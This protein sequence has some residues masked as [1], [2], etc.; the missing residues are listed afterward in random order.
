MIKVGMLIAE[1]YEIIEKIGTGG[2]SDVYRAKCHKLNRFVAVKVLKQEFSENTDFVSKFRVEA[3]A[4]AGLMHP[5]IVNV[6]DV[7]EEN[8]F[9]YIVME[10][11]EGITLK[12]Y[13]EK[14]ARLSVK[15]AVSIAIQVSMGIEAS[16][17]NH[18]IHRDIKPQN[19]IISK[20]G[21]VKVTDFGIAKAATSNTITSSV[22]GS[23][24]YTSPEQV[25]GGF[26][27]E[28]SDIYSLGITL[29]EMLTGRVPFNGETTVAV[30]IKHIQEPM[31]SPRNFVPEIPISVEQIVMKCTQKSPD[32]RYQYAPELIE[33]LKK[34][35]I[36]PDENFVKLDTEDVQGVTKNITS[37]E[38]KEIKRQS[39][40]SV[41]V[42][43]SGTG[44][45][46]VPAEA[47]VAVPAVVPVKE[48]ES[49]KEAKSA[50]SNGQAKPKNGK[51]SKNASGTP[52]KGNGES[53]PKSGAKTQKPSGKNAA[54]SRP[55]KASKSGKPS[56]KPAGAASGKKKKN[57]SNYEEE[58][59]P[60]ME[61]LTTVLIVVATVIIGC[62]FIY[63]FTKALGIN[64]FSTEPVETEAEQ[65]AQVEMIA[66]DNMDAAVA[67]S[68]LTAMG[69]TVTK[70]YE[71]S[72]AVPE[73]QVIR[74][75]VAVGTMVD[76]GSN[77]VLTVSSGANGA[78]VPSVLGLSRAEATAALE[79]EG[80]VVT[81]NHVNSDTVARDNVVSQM[82]EGESHI[83]RG[84]T[85]EITVSLGA[86]E[87]EVQVPNILNQT[88]ED[89]IV[90]LAEAGLAGVMVLEEY[91]DTVE[92]GRVTYQNYSGGLTVNS[93]TEIEFRI[94]MGPEQIFYNCNTTVNAPADYAGG[95][96]VITL[97]GVDGSELH[98]V[99]TSSFPVEINLYN[100]FAISKG[101]ITITYN[102]NRQE[103]VTDAAGNVTV[104]TVQVLTT[105]API[106]V[107]FTRAQ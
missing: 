76:V 87:V 24:H 12:K 92:E 68:T 80:F 101:E 33:D 29:F 73:N 30:A 91:S 47:P 51:N 36:S 64:L 32:R 22:M 40:N 62:I 69:L 23:V 9:Q 46:D 13:I 14:K 78:A 37:K 7:G 44:N 8:G 102:V 72:D 107:N 70:E 67:E 63:F 71:E 103:Q 11:V 31:P 54:P 4:A 95:D 48:K 19:I 15:E 79:R 94:S 6:Y 96:A 5:N 58:Y 49:S 17:N 89:A 43:M 53:A 90:M 98:R 93:G 57:G 35:L 100:I 105:S 66:V 28:K 65:T 39:H 25:R 59:D 60:K 81:V 55:A 99:N 42:K 97:T 75:S 86:E 41:D 88:E 27:D 106:P 56:A 45:M 18:I 1:R 34:S 3:Q 38:L 84:A 104:Q 82:P 61:F 21:K 77:V 74:A 20:E 52:V 2:M 50:S 10:L 85:V 16:H 83:A 26:S